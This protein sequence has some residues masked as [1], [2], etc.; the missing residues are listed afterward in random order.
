[1]AALLVVAACGHGSE[2]SS[3]HPADAPPRLV[4][5]APQSGAVLSLYDGYDAIGV[6]EVHVDRGWASSYVKLDEPADDLAVL[7]QN[8]WA[9]AHGQS[10][11]VVW[12]QPGETPSVVVKLEP[13]PLRLA[14]GDLDHDG[15]VDVVVVSDGSRP[16]LH[17]VRGHAEG[18][19][20]PTH[21]PLDPKGRQTPTL[22]LVDLDHEGTLDI[23][24]GLATGDRDA[25]I[26]DHLRL[27]RNTTHGALVDESVVRVQAPEH[28]D[29]GDFDEDGLPDVLVTGREGA[30]LHLSAGFGWLDTPEK[31]SRGEFSAGRLVDLDRDGHLDI[32]LLRRDRSVLE[33]HPGVGAGREAPVQRYDVGEGPISMAIVERDDERLVVTANA[34]GKSFTTVR[35]ARR[36]SR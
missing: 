33:V 16:S 4:A 8:R 36:P 34:D 24:T 30:W 23:V 5:A 18:F 19:H 29:A 6:H 28:V 22:T 32:V 35:V 7:D 26:P 1:M 10:G 11:R 20:P 25:P 3:T 15:N 17:V 2:N 9:I 31:I 27:F 14:A 12:M 13:A 21:V